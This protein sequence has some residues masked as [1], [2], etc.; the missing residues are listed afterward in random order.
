MNGNQL[1][2]YW[3]FENIHISVGK[4]LGIPTTNFKPEE[5]IV[6]LGAIVSELQTLGSI[7][8]NRAYANWQWLGAYKSEVLGLS[9]DLIQLFPPGLH[10]KNG[11]DIRLALEAVDDANRFPDISHFVIIGGDSDFIAAAQKLRA[12]GKTVIGVGTRPST[13]KYWSMACSCFKYYEDIDTA[14]APSKPAKKSPA[15]AKTAAKPQKAA[16]PKKVASKKAAPAT[17]IQSSA[18]ELLQRGVFRMLQDTDKDYVAL[19]QI[20]PMLVKIDPK[21]SLKGVGHASMS[22]FIQAYPK[23]ARM[24]KKGGAHRVSLVNQTTQAEAPAPQPSV[25]ST[26]ELLALVVNVLKD[27][28]HSR[29]GFV[30]LRNLVLKARAPGTNFST[31][32][33]M[34]LLA[35]IP[36]LETSGTF[37]KLRP[38]SQEAGTH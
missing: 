4:L 9:L 26:K 8:I 15:P 10:A 36:E 14:A 19:S 32:A 29:L 31:I 28:E 35:R 6:D 18:A 34:K 22:K 27:N 17:T 38:T 13:N 16:E 5:K 20:R 24:E 30:A 7:S 33:M 2:I 3:D 12:M 23:V 37:V 11:A 21:F 1:A 25:V